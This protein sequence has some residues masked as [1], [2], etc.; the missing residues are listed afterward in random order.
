MSVTNCRV[1][2]NTKL[3]LNCHF[4]LNFYF[5]KYFGCKSFERWN[6][7]ENLRSIEWQFIPPRV[8]LFACNTTTT[9]IISFE[10][11]NNYNIENNNN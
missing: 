6:G 9:T 3:K 1:F 10:N 8:E 7:D 5:S 4:S 11:N 2:Q